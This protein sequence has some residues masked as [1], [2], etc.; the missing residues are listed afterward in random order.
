MFDTPERIKPGFMNLPT[1]PDYEIKFKAWQ[2]ILG[3]R[4]ETLWQ[5]I[6]LF[7]NDYLQKISGTCDQF[8]L[9]EHISSITVIIVVIASTWIFTI[10]RMGFGW[11]I[12]LLIFAGYAYLKSARRLR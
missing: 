10:F 1:A 4:F 12:I 11:N 6:Q 2:N 3:K 7:T 9:F 5:D 8:F